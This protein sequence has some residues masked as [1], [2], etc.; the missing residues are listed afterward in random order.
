MCCIVVLYNLGC[1]SHFEKK[2]HKSYGKEASKSRS[3]SSK[4]DEKKG[5]ADKS[6]AAHKSRRS[7]VLKPK[8]AVNQSKRAKSSDS[9]VS[10]RSKDESKRA[11]SSSSVVFFSRSKDAAH[12]KRAKSSDSVVSS[13]S[14]NRERKKRDPSVTTKS[15]IRHKDSKRPKI[16][17][18][19]SVRFDQ[20]A[21]RPKMDIF[22]NKITKT[23][24]SKTSEGGASRRCRKSSVSVGGKSKAKVLAMDVFDDDGGFM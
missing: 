24:S 22:A 18:G 2:P 12:K 10:S 17:T 9:I 8:R 4:P 1:F 13:K 5:R 7:E 6:E 14:K 20:T 16:S 21:N 19:A 15:A 23:T 3:K 11:K